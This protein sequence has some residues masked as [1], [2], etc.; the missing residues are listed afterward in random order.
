VWSDTLLAAEQQHLLRFFV[1]AALSILAA[2]TVATLLAARRIRSALLT[3]FAY[4]TAGWGVITGVVAAVRWHSLHLRDVSGAARLEH[5]VW[6]NVGLDLGYAAAGAV[7]AGTAW[8]LGRRLG[9]VGAGIAIVIQGV[10]LFVL[11]LQFAAA[12]SR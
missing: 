8:R 10:A 11:E 3:H 12:V 1:W 5:A 6:L 7:L 2:T 4:Q 9:G